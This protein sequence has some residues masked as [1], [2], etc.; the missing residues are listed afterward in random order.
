MTKWWEAYS[1][2]Y[3]SRLDGGRDGRIYLGHDKGIDRGSRT[4]V[5]PRKS[6]QVPIREAEHMK[7]EYWICEH[8]DNPALTLRFATREEF[9]S[10]IMEAGVRAFVRECYELPR[11]VVATGENVVE[12]I[13]ACL[14]KEPRQK[15]PWEIG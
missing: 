6:D 14:N 8:K 5:V 13:Q 11:T 1:D 15:L 3:V 9:E 2:E 4:V 7:L 12:V 10:F